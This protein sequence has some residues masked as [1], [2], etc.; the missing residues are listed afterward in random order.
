MKLLTFAIY[1]AKVDA[2]SGQ[3][4]AIN[5]ATA[6]RVFQDLV[7]NENSDFAKHP[8]DFSLM[9]T[10]TWDQETAVSTDNGRHIDHGTA[11]QHRSRYL[12]EQ[13][14]QDNHPG[15]PDELPQ[16]GANGP[17]LAELITE[18]DALRATRKES[19]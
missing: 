12:L 13:D 7:M 19:S 17:E 4:T 15:Q 14:Y 2:H 1:D 11:R 16:K 5:I 18:R 10:G 9:E 3:W 6:G 8:G